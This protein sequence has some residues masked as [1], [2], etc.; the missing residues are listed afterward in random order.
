MEENDTLEKF[1]LPISSKEAK[2]ENYQKVIEQLKSAGF[3]NISTEI[4]YDII[5]GWLS[6]DGDVEMITINGEK[7]FS[8]GD[9][10]RADAE[11]VIT[12]HTYRK[13]KP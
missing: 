13:Y 3:R 6:N 8:A 12:Y 5:T 4:Q 9:Q 11:I 2:G 7:K 10:Y 1:D